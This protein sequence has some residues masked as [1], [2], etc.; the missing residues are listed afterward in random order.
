MMNAYNQ[1]VLQVNDVIELMLQ[2]NSE[3]GCVIQCNDE[4]QAYENMHPGK[5]KLEDTTLDIDTVHHNNTTIWFM[6]TKYYSVD[7]LD[8]CLQKVGNDQIKR[9]RIELEYALFEERHLV[10]L[11]QYFIYLVDIMTDNDILWGVGRGSSVA[12]YILFVIGIHSVDSLKYELDITEFL[13]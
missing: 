9:N 13:K 3:V 12:S 11:L 5:L 2:G 1:S 7:V 4:F 8:Y 6:P 10:K